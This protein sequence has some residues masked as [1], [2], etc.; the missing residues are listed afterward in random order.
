MQNMYPVDLE[1]KESTE[2]N[3]SASYLYLI[4]SI[5]RH[6]QLQTSIYNKRDDFN[7]HKVMFYLTRFSVFIS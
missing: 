4:S 7:F 2:R 1:I 3:T 6:G 5:G